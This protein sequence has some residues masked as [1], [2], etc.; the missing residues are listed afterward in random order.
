M[1]LGWRV[2]HKD[3]K[4]NFIHGVVNRFYFLFFDAQAAELRSDPSPPS[5]PGVFVVKYLP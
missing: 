3:T 2:N 5:C 4:A 1:T